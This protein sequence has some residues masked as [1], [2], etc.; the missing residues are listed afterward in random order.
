MTIIT[1]IAETV[2]LMQLGSAR[3]SIPRLRSHEALDALAE[4]INVGLA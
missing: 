4:N 2:F 3:P 1:M